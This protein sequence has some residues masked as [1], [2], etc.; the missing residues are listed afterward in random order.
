MGDADDIKRCRDALAGLHADNLR[1]T[2]ALEWADKVNADCLAKLIAVEKDY[3]RIR[4]KLDE[5][6]LKVTGLTL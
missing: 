2:V 5:I 4:S 6:G 1:L 3:R